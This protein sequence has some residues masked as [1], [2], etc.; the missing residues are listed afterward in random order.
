MSTPSLFDT[1]ADQSGWLFSSICFN[2][3]NSEY[4]GLILKKNATEPLQRSKSASRM[5]LP[6]TLLRAKAVWQASVEAPEPGLALENTTSRPRS[7]SEC[8]GGL[9]RRA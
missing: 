2:A 8:L 5:R 1:S 6:D 9:R 4:Q 3:S 7:A